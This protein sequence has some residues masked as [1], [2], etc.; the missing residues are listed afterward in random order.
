MNKTNAQVI[1]DRADWELKRHLLKYIDVRDL[2][3]TS[4]EDMAPIAVID[5]AQD[6]AAGF[7]LSVLRLKRDFEA[8]LGL[9]TAHYLAG[10]L[11]DILAEAL[12]GTARSFG[13]SIE[14]DIDELFKIRLDRIAV[15][16]VAED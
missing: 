7:A 13:L 16:V 4:K 1:Q 11:H 15:D 14:Y 10:C 9:G 3:N 5:D 6:K 8:T 12:N 2:P